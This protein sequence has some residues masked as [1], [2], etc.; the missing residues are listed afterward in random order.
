M[1]EYIKEGDDGEIVME[2]NN[3]KIAFESEI[4]PSRVL[5]VVERFK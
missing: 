3:G 4:L 1:N 5:P 2:I